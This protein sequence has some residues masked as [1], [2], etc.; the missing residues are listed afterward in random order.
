VSFFNGPFFTGGFFEV[1]TAA[2]GKK[3][4]KSKTKVIRFSDFESREAYAAALR[5]AIPEPKTVI[6]DPEPPLGENDDDNLLIAAISKLI[7]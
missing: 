5:A 4:R 7:H 3:K 2:S 6:V 1:G